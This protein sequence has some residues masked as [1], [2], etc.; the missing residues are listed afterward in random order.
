MFKYRVLFWYP[1]VLLDYIQ[2]YLEE[3]RKRGCYTRQPKY[4]Y[5]F[6]S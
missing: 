6:I 5:N 1:A 3:L 4:I 2:F